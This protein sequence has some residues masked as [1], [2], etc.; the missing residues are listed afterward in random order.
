MLLNKFGKIKYREKSKSISLSQKQI[1][2]KINVSASKYQFYNKI[3]EIFLAN[4]KEREINSFSKS[5]MIDSVTIRNTHANV[6]NNIFYRGKNK[7]GTRNLLYIFPERIFTNVTH[8]YYYM[9]CIRFF[10]L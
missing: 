1:R 2:R 4:N 9:S 6:S 7:K 5:N 3:S 10:Y 8:Y